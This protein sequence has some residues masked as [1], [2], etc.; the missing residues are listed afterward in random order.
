MA[1]LTCEG[2]VYLQDF[3]TESD[4]EGQ[5]P[6]FCVLKVKIYTKSQTGGS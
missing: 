1:F 3:C 4:A 6:D 5:I 2:V